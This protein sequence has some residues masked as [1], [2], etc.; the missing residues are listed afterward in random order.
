MPDH[1]SLVPHQ[2]PYPTLTPK[3]VSSFF[4]TGSLD[5]LLVSVGTQAQKVGL[6]TSSHVSS[7]SSPPWPQLGGGGDPS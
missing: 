3:G 7:C 2:L 5:V 4:S 1:L 6:G